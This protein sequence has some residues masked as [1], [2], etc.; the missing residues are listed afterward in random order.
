MQLASSD[1][2]PQIPAMADYKTEALAY[3]RTVIEETGQTATELARL[4]GVASSTF[5]RPLNVK[6]GHKHAIRFQSLQR[7]ATATGVALP[8]SLIG[9]RREARVSEAVQDGGR[10][11]L[12]IK[13]EVAASG[14]LERDDLPQQPY[15]YRRVT[16]IAPYP[17]HE[18]WLER[19]IS[20]SM[21]KVFPVNSTLHVVSTAH[22]GY[23]PATGDWVIVERTTRNGALVERTVKEVLVTARGVELWPRSHNPRW[24]TPISVAPD[25]ADG[26]DVEVRI[27][28]KV[29]RAYLLFD[30]QDIADEDD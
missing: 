19:V 13:Y 27:V 22:M 14:F 5:T 12:P 17:T 7:L 16:P 4:I 1:A 23:E 20:D 3:L 6:S 30:D 15:G 28:G 25:L 21:D 18:Q 26:S 8:Q 9:A 10:V 24:S 29:F 11:K 2:A